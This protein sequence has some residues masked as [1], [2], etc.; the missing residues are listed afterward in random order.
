MAQINPSIPI[1]GD[2]V[3]TE[4]PKVKTALETIVAAVNALDNANIASGANINGSK[5]LDASIQAAKMAAGL[6]PPSGALM[7]FAGSTAPTGYLICDGSAV[8]RTTYGDL[9]TLLGTTYGSGDGSTT[10]N[11]PNLKGKTIVGRDSADSDFDALGETRGTKTETLTSAQIP[12]HSHP[13]TDPGHS[14][15]GSTNAV[16]KVNNAGLTSFTALDQVTSFKDFETPSSPT[17]TVAS[18]TTGITVG[19]NTG[20]GGSHNNIQPSIVLNYIIKT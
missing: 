9:W 8:S 6:L 18:N 20:G 15:S 3:S 12:A 2:P 1:I 7:P 19:N 13:I 11:L 14:H 10:F 16:Y 17:I 4:E 5:L